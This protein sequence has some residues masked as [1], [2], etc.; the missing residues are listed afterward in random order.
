[1]SANVSRGQRRRDFRLPPDRL[2]SHLLVLVRP[3]VVPIAAL[4]LLFA[5]ILDAQQIIF[6]HRVFAAHGRS[7]QQL[8]IWSAD[9]GTLT[10]ISHTERDHRLPTCDSDGR[11]ILFDDEENG[12]K[13]TRWR[14]D[15]VTGAE[16][17][18]N[19]PGI[20]VTFAREANASS[21]PT[22][23]D[24]G[25]ARV[26]P[27]GTRTACAVDGTDILIV[28]TRTLEGIVRVPFS[29]HYSTGEPYAPWPMESL[30]SPDGRTLLVGIYGENGSSTTA[31]SDYFLLDLTT[32]TW[33]RAFTGVDALWL[34]PTLII[35]VTPRALLPLPS[36]GTHSVWTA[37][38]AAFD[39]A[40]HKARAITSGLSNDL[41]PAVCSP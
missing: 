3:R 24:A 39:P 18:V 16:E 1:V 27:D 28:D 19:T 31:E 15:R 36:G 21:A 22:A 10:Q 34:T 30:W 6:S 20:S 38:L 17:P 23:C 11:H 14:L 8:W 26:S 32:R 35:Y 25:T 40:A 41:S 37:H 29:Q 12:L 13:T 9:A 2:G 4:C 33:T 5:S 7:Y